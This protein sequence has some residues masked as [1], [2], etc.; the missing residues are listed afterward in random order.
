MRHGAGTLVRFAAEAITATARNGSVCRRLRMVPC[1]WDVAQTQEGQ[2]ARTYARRQV[3][4]VTVAR[5]RIGA[6]EPFAARLPFDPSVDA[7]DEAG[8][9]ALAAGRRYGY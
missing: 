2:T 8:M 7:I 5:T 9:R 4:F 3:G 1:S 6:V